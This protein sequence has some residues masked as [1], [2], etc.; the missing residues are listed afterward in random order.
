MIK[1]TSGHASVMRSKVSFDVA[2]LRNGLSDRE[3]VLWEDSAIRMHNII[4]I[5]N[6]KLTKNK[7]KSKMEYY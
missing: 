1:M 4:S 3:D 5:Y 2:W 7:D 6:I